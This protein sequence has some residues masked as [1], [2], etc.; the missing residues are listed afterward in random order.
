MQKIVAGRIVFT[1]LASVLM[2]AAE[3]VGSSPVTLAVQGGTAEFLAKTNVPAVSVKGKSAAMQ[4]HVTLQNGAS[5][6]QL[7]RIEAWL[8]VKTLLTGMSVRDEHMRKY[9]FT[10]ADG[11]APDIRFASERSSCSGAGGDMTCQ[12]SGQLTIRGI[13]K[14]F[15]IP[16]KVHSSGSSFRA[17]GR[18]KVKLSDYG[19]AQP[20]QFGV[21]TTD[22][23]ELHF[24]FT[25]K[26]AGN[27]MTAA[28]GRP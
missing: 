4:G 7:E 8:P 24:D 20:S 21:K 2:L 15:T 22:D 26:P 5:G 23:V 13:A 16:L 9:V 10:T 28:G 27:E 11:Q 17:E 6:A 19:I 3:E 12:V 14:P 1:G 25:A 18:S